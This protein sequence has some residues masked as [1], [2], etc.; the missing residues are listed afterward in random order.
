MSEL[1]DVSGAA[2]R[3]RVSESFLNKL[4]SQG[5][6]PRYLRLGRAVRYRDQDLDD[7]A[8]ARAATST[9]EYKG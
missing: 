9:S 6:G 3:L 4:R 2:Q 1:R 5:G 7:W 8:Q